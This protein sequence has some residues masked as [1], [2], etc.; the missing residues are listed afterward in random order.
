MGRV[1]FPAEGKAFVLVNY[2]GRHDFSYK[3]QSMTKVV[4]KVIQLN[5]TV[6]SR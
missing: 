2:H 3:P 4:G 5:S 1:Y 6:D